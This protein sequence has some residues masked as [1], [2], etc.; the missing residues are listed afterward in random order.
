MSYLTTNVGLGPKSSVIS[1]ESFQRT[2]H[3]QVVEQAEGD[4]KQHVND[5]QADRHLHLEGVQESELVGGHVPDLKRTTGV[6]GE[7]H[8]IV[9]L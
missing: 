9:G 6:K 5:A 2:Q 7:Q 3:L 8:G 4:S 1:H